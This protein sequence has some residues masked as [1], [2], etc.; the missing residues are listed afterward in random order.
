MRD[1]LR[2]GHMTG[3]MMW[4]DAATMGSTCRQWMAT[5]PA[6]ASG[7]SPQAC[8]AMVSWM[9]QH[10]GDWAGWMMSGRMMGQ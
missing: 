2:S 3:T 6:A 7:I 4:G 8:D 1:Q 9:A 10:A 5:G